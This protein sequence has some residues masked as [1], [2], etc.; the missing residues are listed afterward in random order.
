MPPK[1]SRPS[2]TRSPIST[3]IRPKRYRLLATPHW[4]PDVF[5]DGLPS[6][7][8]RYGDGG[9]FRLNWASSQ[10]QKLAWRSG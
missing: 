2:R 9:P 1:R 8:L 7:G 6:R 3:S 10:R 5:S 4:G